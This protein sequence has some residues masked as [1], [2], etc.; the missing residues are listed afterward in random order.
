MTSLEKLKIL[1]GFE[2]ANEDKDSILQ[3]VI[4]KTTD[5]IL[6]YCRIVELPKQLENVMLNMCVDMYRAENLGQGNAQGAVTGITEGDVSVSFGSSAIAAGDPGIT[7][8]RNYTAQLD[9]F[10]KVGW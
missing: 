9:R 8:L 4:D 1:L 10:R 6:N 7:F 5:M 2:P 3:F